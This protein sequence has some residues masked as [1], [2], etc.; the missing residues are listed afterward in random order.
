[1]TSDVVTQRAQEL[2]DEIAAREEQVAQAHR[3]RFLSCVEP[4]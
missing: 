4:A 2:Y 1:M 3:S